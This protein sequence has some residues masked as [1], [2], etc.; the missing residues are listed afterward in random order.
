F[1]VIFPGQ[2]TK[3]ANFLG[4]GRGVDLILYA[5][6]ATLFYLVFRIYILMEDLRHQI[7]EVVRKIALK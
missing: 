1:G 5:S 3:I 6:I 2:T 7:T 4:I